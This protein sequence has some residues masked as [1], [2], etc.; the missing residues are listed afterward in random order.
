MQTTD[1][2][3]N[4]TSHAQKYHYGSISQ[5]S[6]VCFTSNLRGARS[7]Y[8]E[9]LCAVA[10]VGVYTVD[11]AVVLSLALHIRSL[12]RG[13]A[14]IVCIQRGAVIRG[15]CRRCAAAGR[16]P[17][18]IYNVKKKNPIVPLLSRTYDTCITS[19]SRVYYNLLYQFTGGWWW[20][21]SRVT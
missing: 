16:F 18:T 1:E 5:P 7:V 12:A 15:R 21:G 14:Y 11:V 3:R 10:A 17:E 8:D 19:I 6:I 4:D 20:T 13:R 2:K 9:E